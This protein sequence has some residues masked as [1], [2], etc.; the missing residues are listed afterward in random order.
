M[1]FSNNKIMNYQPYCFIIASFTRCE[2]ETFSFSAIL[3][4]FKWVD[5]FVR[6]FKTPVQLSYAKA[7]EEDGSGIGI[8]SSFS[9]SK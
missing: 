4:S 1:I 8:P 5:F 3:M 2:T 6:I 9:P 7:K